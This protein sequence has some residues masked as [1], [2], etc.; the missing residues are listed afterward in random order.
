[1]QRVWPSSRGGLWPRATRPAVGVK[2]LRLGKLCVVR[3]VP[4]FKKE[5]SEAF[6]EKVDRIL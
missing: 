4:W 2:E 3:S 6:A 1:M 5:R